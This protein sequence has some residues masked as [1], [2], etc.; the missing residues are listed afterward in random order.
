MEL[1][2]G[3]LYT[4]ADG[5][6]SRA[7]PSRAGSA[8]VVI[9]RELKRE[10]N[11]RFMSGVCERDFRQ[12][13]AGAEKLAPLQP[14]QQHTRRVT[15]AYNYSDG[16][17]VNQDGAGALSTERKDKIPVGVAQTHTL[18]IALPAC[19]YDVRI[20]IT[21]EVP[22]PCGELA[23]NWEQKRHKVGALRHRS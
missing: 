4:E 17:R 9:T 8:P 11:T 21:V 18:E 23:P 13:F 10:K 5:F 14:G 1:R 22:Q 19:P 2:F 3:L 15:T 16:R 6:L 20:G 12:F 7:F